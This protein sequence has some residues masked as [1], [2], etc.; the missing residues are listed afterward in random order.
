MCQTARKLL[1][2]RRRDVRVVEGARLESE[3]G[4]GYRP[5]S[6]RSNTHPISDLTLQHDHSVMRLH[7]LARRS[8]LASNVVR[9]HAW[10]ARTRASD[11]D[12]AGRRG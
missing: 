3:A 2:L 10:A 6:K 5:T 9:R 12:A 4:H 11:R 8:N 1:I 7:G